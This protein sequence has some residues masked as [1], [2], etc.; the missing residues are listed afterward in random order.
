MLVVDLAKLQ[1]AV[2]RMKGF[3]KDV[4]SC[5]EEVDRTMASLRASWHGDA[6][7]SQAQSQARWDE[8]AEQMK[9]ALAQLQKIGQQAHT[10]YSDAAKKNIE[11]WGV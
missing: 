8:G 7:D 3:E 1:A 4:E 5:L 11:M 2:N 6:S 10:N 9:N